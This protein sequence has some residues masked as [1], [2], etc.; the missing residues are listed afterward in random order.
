M[1]AADLESPLSR[2][3]GD[4]LDMAPENRLAWVETIDP[5]YQHLKPRLR[6]LL[7]RAAEVESRDFLN[8]LPPLG[9]DE[10]SDIDDDNDSPPV[11]SAGAR[12]GPYRL[13]RKMGSGGMGTVWLAT[14]ADGLF[15]RS[16]A[17]KLPHRG[18]FGADLAERMARERSILA[19]LD[20]PNIARLYDAG[21]T[22]DGQPY[23]AIEY[24]EGV[25][26]DEYCR[27]KSCSVRGRLQLFL[28][29]TRAV[30][31]AHARLVVHRDLKPANILVAADGQVRLLDFGIAKLLDTPSQGG[32][33]K[34][35]QLSG[36]ALTPDYASP[37][38]ILGEPIT[39]ASDVYSLGV[40]LYELLAGERPYRLRRDTRGALEDA[41]LLTEPRRPSDIAAAPAARE[42]RGDV[43]TIVLK[44][45]HKHVPDRYA[46]ANALADDI[47][48]FLEG[49]PVLAQPDST[50]YRTSRFMRRNKL[51]VAGAAV[52]A[53]ALAGG[54]VI[55]GMGLQ[56]ARAAE[57]K[58][59]VDAEK[60]RQVSNFLVDV[61]KV[62]DPGESRGN[63]ITAREILDEASARVTGELTA[64]PEIRAAMMATMADVYA[65]LGLFAD[66][67][68]L[69]ELALTL[70][71]TDAPESVELADSLDQVG[72]IDSLLKKAKEAEPLH[73]R[74]LD[75]RRRITPTDHTAIARTLKH[76]GAAIYAGNDFD[77]ALARFQEARLELQQSAVRDPALLGEV[78]KYMAN[79]HHEHSEY[80]QAIPLYREALEVL[81]SSLGA[82]HPS[83]AGVLGDLAIALKDTQQFTEAEQAY[84]AALAIQRKTLGARHPDVANSLSNISVML[85]DR[86]RFDDALARAQEATDILRS[87]L[88][89]NHDLTN[90]AR[91]NAAR[92]R[93]QLGQYEAAE[94]EY[95][96]IV[97]IRRS[98]RPDSLELAIALDALADV[99]NRQSRY[100]DSEP[101][102]RESVA[103]VEKSVG[104]DQWRFAASNRTLGV[105]L[106]GKRKY[107][108]AESV[109]RASYDQLRRQRGE[110]NR[111]T[112]LTLQRL[113][114][115]Y[116]AWGKTQQAN[117]LQAQLTKLNN[118]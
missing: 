88:G 110:S 97:Q 17:L 46:T 63:S 70:R 67:A 2:L 58:A 93:T 71:L 52:V 109:L 73:L 103:M 81:R 99:L 92:A 80:Q 79:L 7:Q 53:V 35:T 115:L 43:D 45:L 57:R 75:L 104:R 33:S 87:S 56:Q 40:V 34:L 101:V 38:Q 3:L 116:N 102:A 6:A 26:I 96:A 54:T 8:A 76:L 83:V 114:D 112:L 62:S 77:G 29:V 100:E 95:R 41:I 23:L 72:E 4:A 37:E 25:A 89:D 5:A 42:L 98:T 55:A 13:E 59:V 49:R 82:D 86:G 22:A 84:E 39:I 113:I 9:D 108:E 111:T 21:L 24:V 15:E 91:V 51:A 61:F 10:S 117:E 60:A 47:Q 1:T 50:W 16:I 69:A 18:M 20:H 107:P 19:A 30:A 78:I 14:R 12:V 74:A 48:R 106:T 65:K 31:S 27:Q 64:A 36:H 66:A 85:M 68:K 118:I 90:I 105:A 44:A 11:E 28:Q 32:E 94:S